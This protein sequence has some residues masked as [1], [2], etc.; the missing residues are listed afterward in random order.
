MSLLKQDL[1][2]LQKTIQSVEHIQIDMDGV[3]VDDVGM[4]SELEPE[5]KNMEGLLK[6][7]QITGQRQAY[8]LP[9]VLTAIDKNLFATAPTTAFYTA[10]KNGLLQSWLDRGIKVTILT[11]TMHNNP[12]RK[13]LEE[14]KLVWLKDKGLDH[15]HVDF[16][17]GSAKKQ[18]HATPTTLL[19]DDYD[20]TIGQYRS[21]GGIAIQ[22]TTLQSVLEQLELL[23]LYEPFTDM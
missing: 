22:Y 6:Y 21:K 9:R 10:L 14:Q 12:K 4:F 11:S 19:I 18:E 3:I 20:R 2:L 1:E 5:V 13:E 23:G 7:L 17:E 16:A 8:V 15:L